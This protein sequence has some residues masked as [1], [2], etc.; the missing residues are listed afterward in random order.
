MKFWL[1][2]AACAMAEG[3]IP[4]WVLQLGEVELDPLCH[5]GTAR[6]SSRHKALPGPQGR[7][8]SLGGHSYT[9]PVSWLQGSALG[10]FIGA[11]PLV[12]LQEGAPQSSFRCL[13]CSVNAILDARL[14][15]S[16]SV[17]IG[18]WWSWGAV[19]LPSVISSSSKLLPDFCKLSN[20]F[21]G[22][23]DDLGLPELPV[24]GSEKR[25]SF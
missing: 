4:S 21:Q 18:R 13:I 24:T 15:A 7:A 1:G 8:G 6:A 19:E 22:D 12:I 20:L 16:K 5:T 11:K 10:F 14:P 3:P 9:P 2:A 23:C 17:C 25:R